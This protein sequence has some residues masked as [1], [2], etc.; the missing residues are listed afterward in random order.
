MLL[1]VGLLE[2]HDEGAC[3][4]EKR[5]AGPF[6]NRMDTASDTVYCVLCTVCRL[7]DHSVFCS[8]PCCSFL[9]ETSRSVYPHVQQQ[10]VVAAST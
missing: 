3:P 4:S 6:S 8:C 2:N 9:S 5:T 7:V 10:C 1:D